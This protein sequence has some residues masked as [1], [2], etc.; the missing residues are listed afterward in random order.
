MIDEKPQ[1]NATT[2]YTRLFVALPLFLSLLLM[3]CYPPM[4][5]PLR[6]KPVTGTGED[7]KTEPDTSVINP[8]V[9]TRAEIL[10]QFAA[11]DTGWKGERLFLGRWAYSGMVA[12]GGRW[13][14]GKIL[15]VEFDEKG[16]VIRYRVLSDDDFLQDQD[17][18]PLASAKEEEGDRPLHSIE[19]KG[20]RIEAGE[21]EQLSRWSYATVYSPSITTARDIGVVI[22]LKHKI[23]RDADV[24]KKHA[25]MKIPVECNVP[26]AVLLMRLRR[27]SA[28]STTKL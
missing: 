14:A 20:Y 4:K 24:E 3:G 22:H 28:D 12:H 19:I 17:S 8:S 23:Y 27:T 1:S 6:V 10:H 15:A 25:V 21:I 26:T 16:V 11:F 7:L 9:T 2:Q 18:W 5:M 13:W